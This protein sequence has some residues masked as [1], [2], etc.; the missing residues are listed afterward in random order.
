MNKSIEAARRA[1]AFVQFDSVLVDGGENL[2]AGLDANEAGGVF[3]QRRRRRAP[4][5]RGHAAAADE[6]ENLAVG[7]DNRFRPGFGRGRRARAHHGGDAKRFSGGAQTGG[8]VFDR[9][10]PLKIPPARDF[11]FERGKSAGAAARASKS[12]CAAAAAKPRGA[13]APARGKNGLSQTMRRALRRSARICF[14]S[15]AGGSLS[16]PSLTIKTA[17]RA[18]EQT[19]G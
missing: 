9:F 18:R 16:Q 19:E 11:G 13:P 7:G 2:V 8:G 3:G 10:H 4:R 14:S 15:S 1:S 5:R 17:P 6:S 12:T